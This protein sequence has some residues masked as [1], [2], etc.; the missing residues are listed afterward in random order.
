MWST[1][2]AWTTFLGKILVCDRLTLNIFFTGGSVSVR[3]RQREEMSCFPVLRPCLRHVLMSPTVRNPR[4]PLPLSNKG[5]RFRARAHVPRCLHNCFL[6]EFSRTMRKRTRSLRARVLRVLP[7]A[8]SVFIQ[9]PAP[10]SHPRFVRTRTQHGSAVLFEAIHMR[11][12]APSTTPRLARAAPHACRRPPRRNS[13]QPAP[14][15]IVLVRVIVLFVRAR[16]PPG[17]ASACSSVTC[18]L[19][20]GLRARVLRVTTATPSVF[21]QPSGVAS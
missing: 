20:V 14:G 18:A 19:R 2:S 10:T 12:S 3:A 5:A 11:S 16:L 6:G 17:P 1:W 9:H 7:A 13:I 4:H 21:I 8:P 15:P